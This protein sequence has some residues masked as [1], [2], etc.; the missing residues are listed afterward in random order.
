MTVDLYYEREVNSDTLVESLAE[1]IANI[2]QLTVAET[3]EATIDQSR[4][5][6]GT[7]KYHKGTYSYDVY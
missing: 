5:L 6:V 1:Q 2:G 7:A 4:Q 3:V